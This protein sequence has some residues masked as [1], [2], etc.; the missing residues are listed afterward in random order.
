MIA[1]LLLVT[2]LQAGPI[3]VDYRGTLGEALNQIASKGGI[4]LIATGDL[5]VP[6]EVHLKDVTAEEALEALVQVHHLELHKQGKLWVVKPSSPAAEGGPLPPPPAL[7]IG[8]PGPPPPGSATAKDSTPETLEAEAEAA[9][10]RA[11][12]AEERAEALRDEAEKIREAKQTAADAQ[13]DEEEARL[14][15]AKAA[16]EEAKAKAHEV[17]HGNGKK[18]VSTGPVV[19]PDGQVVEDVVSYGGPVTLGDGVVAEGD[20]VAFGGDV[21][22]G[23]GVVVNGDAVSFGGTVKEGQ[24]CLVK[25]E[26]VSFGAGGFG[27]KPL[28]KALPAAK[29]VEKTESRSGLAAFLINFATFFGLG[30]LLMMFAPNRM[31][32]I[33][34]ELKHEPV[35][36]GLAGLL[37]LIGS[38]PLTV[39]LVLTVIGIPVAVLM[40]LLGGLSIVMGL[41]CFANVLGTRFPLARLRRTQAAVLAV[42]LLMIMGV[43]VVP[44]VGPLALFV[45]TCVSF[46][47]I[48]R[49]RV[50]QRSLGLPVP[51]SPMG[52]VGA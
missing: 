38:V 12:E 35:K 34:A 29:V 10:K 40:W 33:E 42:G 36:S 47:A 20:V 19:V 4:N 41:L 27:I 43:S 14:E 51:E 17:K 5:H 37:A 13:R 11:A 3:S 22:L 31:R 49:T 46:G 32:N 50:G 25:G 24:G 7:P 18:R 21:I 28:V 16:V 26:K 1:A 48:I 44:V 45:A 39:L 2:A 30:F 52:E 15:E 8:P 6:A 23:D 9:Q